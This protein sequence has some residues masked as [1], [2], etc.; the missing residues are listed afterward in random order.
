MLE[1][2]GLRKQEG[3]V[4]G[5]VGESLVGHYLISLSLGAISAGGRGLYSARTA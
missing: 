4:V 3:S 2:R 1:S 5:L